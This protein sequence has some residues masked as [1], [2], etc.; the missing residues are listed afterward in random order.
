MCLIQEQYLG[1]TETNTHIFTK[2]QAQ[3]TAI[4]LTITFLWGLPKCPSVMEGIH[5]LEVHF[6]NEKNCSAISMKYGSVTVHNGID[7]SH[8]HKTLY[9]KLTHKVKNLENNSCS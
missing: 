1:P 7:T 4:L 2:R 9:N 3:F 8:K 6:H 5:E